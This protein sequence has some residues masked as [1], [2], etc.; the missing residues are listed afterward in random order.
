AYTEPETPGKLAHEIARAPGMS[1]MDSSVRP[2]GPS[3]GNIF[4]GASGSRNPEMFNHRPS[5]VHFGKHL[6]QSI[7]GVPPSLGY[8]LT[9][10]VRSWS[11]AGVRETIQ[12]PSGETIGE[13][14]AGSEI[15]LR[16]APDPSCNWKMYPCPFSRDR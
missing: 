8:A 15:T 1:L 3:T 4:P 10:P 12:W 16:I 6:A 2:P 7:N 14:I 9:T 11:F 5:D 13:L